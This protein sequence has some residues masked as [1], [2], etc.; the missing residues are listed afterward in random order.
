MSP[1]LRTSAEKKE[2][3]SFL[4]GDE[5]GTIATI[6]KTRT[7]DLRSK[8]FENHRYIIELSHQRKEKGKVD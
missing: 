6:V 7:T 1:D 8:V 4:K 2:I 5:F 3:L